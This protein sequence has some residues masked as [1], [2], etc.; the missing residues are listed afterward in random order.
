MKKWD[1]HCAKALLLLAPLALAV[2]LVPQLP[3]VPAPAIVHA[4][5]VDDAADHQNLVQRSVDTID[6]M[7]DLPNNFKLVDWKARGKALIDFVFNPSAT[8]FSEK[9]EISVDPSRS[10]S[11]IYRDDRYGGYMLPAFYGE[12]R[13]LTDNVANNHYGADDQESISVTSGLISASLMGMNVN[14]ELPK[15]LQGSVAGEVKDADALNIKYETYLD[16]ALKFF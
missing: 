6:A 12:D 16:D 11:T 15:E 8:N 3:N 9:T 5:T 1:S 10:F 2:T 4:A 7:P 14:Q 13:P